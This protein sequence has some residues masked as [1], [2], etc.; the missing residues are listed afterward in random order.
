MVARSLM[1]IE[2]ATCV[3]FQLASAQVAFRPITVAAEMLLSSSGSNARF[4]N[5]FTLSAAA[6]A[7][8]DVAV[9]VRASRWFTHQESSQGGLRGAFGAFGQGS[10]LGPPWLEARLGLLAVYRTHMAQEAEWDPT[11]YTAVIIV[12]RRGRISLTAGAEV[13]SKITLVSLASGLNV[14]TQVRLWGSTQ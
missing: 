14:G 10:W 2:L 4:Q 11:F 9:G 1:A 5:G 13:M 12:Y 6:Q 8:G 7:N 3:G